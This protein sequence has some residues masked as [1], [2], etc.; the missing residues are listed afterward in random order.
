MA[1]MKKAINFIRDEDGLSAKDYLMLVFTSVY[2][3]Q[4][5]TCFILALFNKLPD[6]VT[7]IMDSLDAVVITIIGG[8]FSI[9][10]VQEF[11]KPQT[12][13]AI[14]LGSQDDDQAVG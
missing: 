1:P 8:V 9:T 3:L 7:A 11:R 5:L 4:Q 10:A 12:S 13:G 6:G 14:D 2:I